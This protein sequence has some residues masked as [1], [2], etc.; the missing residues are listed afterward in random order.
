MILVVLATTAY[1]RF[2]PAAAKGR[3][4][5]NMRSLHISFQ[6]YVTDHNM[7]PQMPLQW[8]DNDASYDTFWINA[9]KPYNDDERVWQCPVLARGGLKGVSGQPLK[10]H[11]IPTMFD[12]NPRSMYRWPRQPWLIEMGDAH[13]A[14]AHILF[15]DGS[16]RAMKEILR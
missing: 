12:A 6:S 3:C 4:M 10:V 9:L 11:Y 2:L 7:W 16:I 15:P 5:A 8:L 13:G 14:G 1:K